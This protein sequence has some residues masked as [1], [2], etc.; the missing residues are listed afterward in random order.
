MREAVARGDFIEHAEVRFVRQLY[1]IRSHL[2]WDAYLSPP[3]WD[4]GSST[5]RCGLTLATTSILLP[6]FGLPTDPAIYFFC[7][8]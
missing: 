1:A 6:G 2:I 5:L 4:H 3:S 8:V 7:A